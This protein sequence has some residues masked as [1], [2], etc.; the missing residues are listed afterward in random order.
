MV[1]VRHRRRDPDRHL[2]PHRGIRGAAALGLLV[3]HERAV[4][5]PLCPAAIRAHRHGRVAWRHRR[6]AGGGAHGG[7]GVCRHV[8]AVVGGPARAVRSRAV[9]AV[10]VAAR[11]ATLRVGRGADVRAADFPSLAPGEGDRA[12]RGPRH[13]ECRDRGLPPQVAR[14]HRVRRRRPAAVLRDLLHGRPGRHVPGPGRGGW[15]AAEATRR[16]AFGHDAAAGTRCRRGGVVAVPD[17]HGV[18]RGA[19]HRVRAARVGVPQRL[20]T[21]VLGDVPAGE[22]AGEDVPRRRVRPRRRCPWC[23][24]RATAAADGAAVRGQRAAGRGAAD[25]GGEHLDRRTPRRDVPAQ[26]RAAP[27]GSCR[28]RR[29]REP[30]RVRRPQP[31]Q[32]RGAGGGTPAGARGRQARA[33]RACAGAGAPRRAAR[34][35]APDAIGRS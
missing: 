25:G 10:W 11:P 9:A 32:R 26:H 15:T 16:R 2:H 13:G 14:R 21:A 24:H 17:D 6:R 4:R 33:P 7:V 5:P 27:R 3:P 31:G 12:A 30:V 28:R 8:A 18:R 19:G 23:R 34:P 22:A 29:L 1:L 35:V 20:R